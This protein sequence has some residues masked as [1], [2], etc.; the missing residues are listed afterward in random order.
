MQYS[1]VGV[2]V[3]MVQHLLGP[4]LWEGIYADRKEAITE[5]SVVPRQEHLM[6]KRFGSLFRVP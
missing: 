1:T 6:L 2:M 5:E 3:A 4:I